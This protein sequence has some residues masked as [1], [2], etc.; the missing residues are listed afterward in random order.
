MD[1]LCALHDSDEYGVCRW[2]LADLAR[3]AGINPESA[4]EL[5]AKDVLK[6]ADAGAAPFVYRPFHAGSHGD[7]V[8]LIEPRGTPVWFS[9]RLVVD[10][11][12]RQQ[13]GVNTRFSTENQPPKCIPIRSPTRTIGERQGDGSISSPLSLNYKTLP[14]DAGLVSASKPRDEGF[15]EFWKAYTPTRNAKKPDALK[16][17]ISHRQ[18][19]AAAP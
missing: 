1:V 2:P 16:A 5:V 7:E 11:W 6:G 19:Q 14:A 13:R 12:R 4:Q 18:N 9:S 8:V 3:A 10:E 15:E 17:W